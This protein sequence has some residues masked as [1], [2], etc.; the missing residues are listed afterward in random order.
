MALQAFWLALS[1][2]QSGVTV[3]GRARGRRRRVEPPVPPRF[4]IAVCARNEQAVVAKIV[5]D[6]LAQDYP[7]ERFDVTVIAHNCTDSTAHVAATA[8]ANVIELSTR[9]KGKAAAVRASL[10]NADDYD[11]IGIFDA[12]ARIPRSLLSEVAEASSGEDCLQVETIPHES[13]DWLVEGYGLG[14]RVRN[15]LWWRPRENLGLGTTVTGSG[16]F[17]RPGVLRELVPQLKTLTEDLELTARLYASGRKVAYVSTTY[18]VVEEPKN[19]KPSLQQR[20]R[21]ARGHLRV[22]ALEWWPMTRRGLRGD[23]PFARHRPLPAYA[24]ADVDAACRDGIA[25][26]GRGVSAVFAASRPVG[27]RIRRRMGRAGRRRLP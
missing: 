24:D 27:G 12:D 14:R 9:R 1:L 20:V 5:A 3:A 16:W 2:Y 17:I 22:V 8:G 13:N 15:A 4:F 10:A 6:L 26:A 23:L 7:R 18:V 25:R 11:F 21:W 19:L